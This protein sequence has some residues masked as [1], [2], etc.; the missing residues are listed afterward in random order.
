MGAMLFFDAISHGV[1]FVS[2]K[3]ANFVVSGDVFTRQT[4]YESVFRKS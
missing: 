1:L 2:E 3:F 4:Y